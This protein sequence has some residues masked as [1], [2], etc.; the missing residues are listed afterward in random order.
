MK[1]MQRQSALSPG[2]AIALV[3]VMSIVLLV[4]VVRLFQLQV[5]DGYLYLRRAEQVAGRSEPVFA[6]RGQIFDRNFDLP[7]ATNRA[8]FAL[9]YVRGDRNTEFSEALLTSIAQ[10][11]DRDP[12]ELLERLA[13]T[14][15]G[16][17]DP[18][19]VAVG[20]DLGAVVRIAERADDF[21]GVAWYPRPERLYPFGDLFAHV[22]GYVG[23]IT[24]QELQVL[25]NQGYTATSRLGK[26][27]VEQHYDARL[28]GS[29]GRRTFT[30]DASGRRVADTESMLPPV[31]GHDLVL[32]LDRD[33]QELAAQ[34]LGERN[35]SVVVLRPSSG[36]ILA[37]YSYPGF[38]ANDFAT[39]RGSTV[40][41]QLTRDGASPFLNRTI[42]AVAAP[43][44]TF[45]VVMTAAILGEGLVDPMEEV[46]C[47]GNFS[48]GNREFTDWLST[49][50]GRINMYEALAQSCNV[51]FWTIGSEYADVDTIISYSAQLG[52]GSATGVD[53]PGELVGLIPSPAW[54][55]A[56]L[57]ERW[58]GGDTVNM[59]IGEGY[60]QVT[61]LQLANM[62]AIIVNDGVAYRPHVLREI[63]DSTTGTVIHT[64]TPEV[65]TR[66]D[67]TPE[68]FAE[69]RA[70]MRGV[71][72]EGTARA[73][74]T[75]PSV[76]VAGK[77]GTGQ[78][79]GS[80]TNWNSWFVAYAPFG[81][82]VPADERIVVV[83][84]VDASNEWEWWAPKAANLILH[85]YFNREDYAATV[86]DLR[87]TP[88]AL[89]YLES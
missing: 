18:V 20:L 36:E 46:E 83:V 35:G 65:I 32:T 85:G 64:T 31:P 13:T 15:S 4:Y 9:S 54:K 82:N 23:Q 10:L 58:R 22:V 57:G 19:E 70:A 16:R 89:W 60:L 34:A 42:Q 67:I 6:E 1:Y 88:G 73:V 43:A 26:G 71:I 27:G 38:N 72:T 74:I 2:R 86:A 63:R 39:R 55:E 47:R 11:I 79:G 45:K 25:F 84:M 21:P 29:D 12:A 61:P 52:L 50:H 51:Y 66:A 40:F 75:T 44:S 49:G 76:P 37:L 77:T 62:V 17:F 48:F 14:R 24:P 5:L 80:E 53:L 78:I 59:S 8:S 87:R 68:V 33:V 7:I 41:Q 28:R 3:V 81:E 56:R 69:V 30:V